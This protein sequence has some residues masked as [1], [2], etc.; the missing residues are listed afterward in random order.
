MLSWMWAHLDVNVP[1]VRM[2]FL[3]RTYSYTISC[4]SCHYNWPSQLK[5]TNKNKT[6]QKNKT[7]T[8]TKQN[9]SKQNKNKKTKNKKQ[10]KNP[11]KQN[12][13]KQKQKEEVGLTF[14]AGALVLAYNHEVFR[15]E[16]H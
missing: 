15:F 2:V 11:K 14:L 12:K 4:Y 3:I 5:P 16:Y 1:I 7:K 8:K 10:K 9:K 13:T 6:K